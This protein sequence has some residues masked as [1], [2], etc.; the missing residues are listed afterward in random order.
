VLLAAYTNINYKRKWRQRRNETSPNTFQ[1]PDDGEIEMGDVGDGD[2]GSNG[3]EYWNDMEE[4]PIVDEGDDEPED[5]LDQIKQ[6]SDAALTIV[7]V[8]TVNFG[9]PNTPVNLH[10]RKELS[11]SVS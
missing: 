3:D 5:A 2:D 4:I 11:A 8:F 1:R 6:R 7:S 9:K 10:K